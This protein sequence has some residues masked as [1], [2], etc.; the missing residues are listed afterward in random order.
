M[1]LSS[2]YLKN[3]WNFTNERH[4]NCWEIKQ[5]YLQDDPRW[6]ENWLHSSKEQ[7]TG[8]I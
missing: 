8:A 3:S 1:Y 5:L 6:N 4:S 7:K 2:V